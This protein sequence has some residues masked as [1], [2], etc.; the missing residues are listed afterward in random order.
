MRGER[1]PLAVLD[2]DHR[3]LN[4]RW[5]E[6]TARVPDPNE[7]AAAAARMAILPAMAAV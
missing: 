6:R 1:L 5:R 7:P 4:L 3:R 2:V